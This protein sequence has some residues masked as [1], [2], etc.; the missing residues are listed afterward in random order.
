MNAKELP[1]I[2]DYKG[3]RSRKSPDSENWLN[4]YYVCEDGEERCVGQTHNI[5]STAEG[6]LRRPLPTWMTKK[7][8]AWSSHSDQKRISST[9][10]HDVSLSELCDRCIE[11]YGEAR[12]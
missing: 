4:A 1:I 7:P 6:Y 12:V 2:E 10:G 11:S 8:E 5:K 9:C 3:F